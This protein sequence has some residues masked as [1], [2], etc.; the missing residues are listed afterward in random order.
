MIS[1]LLYAALLVLL[2]QRTAA[3]EVKSN[4]I[5]E[6]YLKN[7]SALLDDL[8][9]EEKHEATTPTSFSATADY[10]STEPYDPRE[11]MA[12]AKTEPTVQQNLP[13]RKKHI[14]LAVRP[15]ECAEFKRWPD[16]EEEEEME[17][18]VTKDAEFFQAEAGVSVNISC[19]SRAPHQW[20]SSAPG[21]QPDVVQKAS[22]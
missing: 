21:F 1:R 16:Q 7:V 14:S 8:E 6:N 22:A 2:Y 15:S 3:S 19:L 18:L 5:L 4:S 11:A 9:G 10:M 20:W 13:K 17:N 12:T